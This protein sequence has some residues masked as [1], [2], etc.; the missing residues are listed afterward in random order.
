M[1]C[2]VF[3]DNNGEINLAKAPK[4]IPRTKDITLKHHHFKE[5]VRKGL[6]DTVT[7]DTG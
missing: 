7:I 3:E 1:R 5:H 6:I 2:K 4:M